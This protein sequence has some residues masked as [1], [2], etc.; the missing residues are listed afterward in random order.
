MKKKATPR[1]SKLSIPALRDSLKG[2][3]KQIN[4]CQTEHS[5]LT[6]LFSQLHNLMD[7][8]QLTKI[9]IELSKAYDNAI[10]KADSEL[11]K[12]LEG[13]EIQLDE[14]FS[15]QQDYTDRLTKAESEM[16]ASNIKVQRPGSSAILIT[17]AYDVEKAESDAWITMENMHLLGM[18]DIVK[19]DIMNGG[20]Y[21]TVVKITLTNRDDCRDVEELMVAKG[22]QVTHSYNRKVV[23]VFK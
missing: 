5:K 10:K 15:K 18:F 9:A 22:Y 4:Y 6:L 20:E 16:F 2:I 19:K 3:A 1:K 14:L 7:T 21:K 8:A 12:S 11:T 23:T 13:Y 17:S